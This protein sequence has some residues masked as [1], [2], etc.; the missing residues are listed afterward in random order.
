LRDKEFPSSRTQQQ[1][2]LLK[3]V[4]YAVEKSVVSG[5]A[6]H[7]GISDHQNH[8]LNLLCSRFDFK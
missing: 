2:F 7:D 8:F 3:I 4:I 6:F 5:R 1:Y